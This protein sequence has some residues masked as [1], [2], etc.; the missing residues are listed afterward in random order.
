[1]SNKAM[2]LRGLSRKAKVKS[3]FLRTGYLK[4]THW[5]RLVR[6]G[7]ELSA[8]PIYINDTPGLS[9]DQIRFATRKLRSKTGPLSLIISDYLGLIQPTVKGRTKDEEI[10]EISSTAKQLARE[11]DCPYLMVCQ[12]NRRCETRTDKRPLLS[13]LRDSGN[14]EQDSDMVICIYRDEVYYPNTPEAGIAEFLVR[15]NR[16]GPVGTR[17]LVWLEDYTAFQE[18]AI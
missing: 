3:Q 2:N 16:N 13:D 7:G 12:L 1:M 14:I 9:I 11:M 6:A 15:K 17:K 18:L 10:G 5:S 8:L 4:D